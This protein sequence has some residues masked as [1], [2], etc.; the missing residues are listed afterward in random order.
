MAFPGPYATV[1]HNEA[2]E[3]I[4]WSDESSYEPEFDEF[5]VDVD[6]DDCEDEDLEE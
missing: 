6:D 1:Y 3:P 2:G 4:G 5:D